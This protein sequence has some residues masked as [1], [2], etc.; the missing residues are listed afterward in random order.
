MRIQRQ[1]SLRG[2]GLLVLA[3]DVAFGRVHFLSLPLYESVLWLTT[4]L[5]EKQRNKR[6][7]I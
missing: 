6:T 7:E 2:G 4:V 5:Y 3:R 1:M